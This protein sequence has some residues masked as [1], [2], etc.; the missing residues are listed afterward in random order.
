MRERFALW[1][2]QRLVRTGLRRSNPWWWISLAA[3]YALYPRRAQ[4]EFARDYHA[5]ILAAIQEGGFWITDDFAVQQPG[6]DDALRD[7]PGA[8]HQGGGSRMSDNG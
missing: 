2:L 7:S 4:R 3:W 8:A 6:F 1:S 5:R